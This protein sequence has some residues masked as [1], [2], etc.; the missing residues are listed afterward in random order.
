MWEIPDSNQIDQLVRRHR[1]ADCFTRLP[2]QLR[3]FSYQRGELLNYRQGPDAYILFLVQGSLSIYAQRDDG[4]RYPIQRLEPPGVLGDMEFAG[5]RSPNFIIEVHRPALCLAVPLAGQR[6]Q[7]EKDARF[8]R[9]LLGSLA[10]KM[11]V[12]AQ[13][14]ADCQTVEQKLLAY[15]QS[16][17]AGQTMPGV[18]HT[19]FQL[20][21][22][23]RQLQRALKTLLEGQILEKTGRGR[24]RLRPPSP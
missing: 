13:N 23:R 5:H 24:Y 19:C 3:L 7:L 15:L 12:M 2:Q 16:L 1:L 4:S 11:A 8:L 10:Q 20:H 21:C 9:F 17:P 14:E 22:S 6:D 18:E